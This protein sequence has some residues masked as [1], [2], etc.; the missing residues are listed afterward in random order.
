MTSDIISKLENWKFHRGLALDILKSLTDEQL[1]L[2][3]GKHMGKMP[4][5]YLRGF[6]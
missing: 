4:Q 3:I 5:L 6:L 2:T 1:N